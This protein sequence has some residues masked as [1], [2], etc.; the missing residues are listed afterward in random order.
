MTQVIYQDVFF[1]IASNFHICTH[2]SIIHFFFF[3]L[4]LPNYRWLLSKLAASGKRWDSSHALNLMDD[5][6]LWRNFDLDKKNEIHYHSWKDRLKMSKIWLRIIVK[7][8]K[9]SPVKFANFVYIWITCG[10]YNHFE[11]K[12]VINFTAR[13]TNIYKICELHKAIFSSFYN[14]CSQLWTSL[15]PVVIIL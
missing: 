14:V 8:G 1:N 5:S 9:Y 15:E 12:V 4:V 11:P 6:S 3:L 7:W 2:V 10:E 13:N